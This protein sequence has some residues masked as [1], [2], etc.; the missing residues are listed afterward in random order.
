MEGN[1]NAWG[2]Q[3]VLRN[4]DGWKYQ[5]DAEKTHTCLYIIG[6]KLYLVL[7]FSRFRCREYLVVS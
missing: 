5:F 3:E 1:R 7:D 6:A 2:R 4:M